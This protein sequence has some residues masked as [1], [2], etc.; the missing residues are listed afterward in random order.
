MEHEAKQ[1]NHKYKEMCERDANNLKAQFANVRSKIDEL[2]SEIGKTGEAIETLERNKI[3][4]IEKNLESESEELKKIRLDLKSIGKNDLQKRLEI[5]EKLKVLREIVY[6][7]SSS[8]LLEPFQ[9]SLGF[10]ELKQKVSTPL[11]KLLQLLQLD[12]NDSQYFKM[13]SLVVNDTILLNTDSKNLKSEHLKKIIKILFQLKK[14]FRKTLKDMKF[15]LKTKKEDLKKKKDV[16]E[17]NIKSIIENLNLFKNTL[18]SKKANKQEYE[19]SLY[20]LAK[21]HT[22][23]RDNA[24]QRNKE[25]EEQ[26]RE[27][28]LLSEEI[29]VQQLYLKKLIGKFIDYSPEEIKKV[30]TKK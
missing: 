6:L 17:N 13:L 24:I 28:V 25:C 22:E 27:F 7:L 8:N 11:E 12:D 16:V 15:N 26:D 2:K 5:R 30:L 19:K 18:H 10:I 9:N 3:P 14:I 29:S 21:Y 20:E 1:F 23:H 4:E